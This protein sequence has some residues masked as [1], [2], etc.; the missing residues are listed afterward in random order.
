MHTTTPV[1]SR[2]S[3]RHE[4]FLWRDSEQFRSEL[5][6]FIEE[7]LATGEAVM[8][9]LITEHA[10]WL[11]AGLGADAAA[12]VHFVDM[13][14]LGANPARVI[15]A[16]QQFLDNHAGY[17]QPAR[18][19]GEPIWAG[20]R[21]EEVQE[22][23]LH[24]ALLNVAID[25]ELPFWLICPYNST[26]L[27]PAVIS[28]AHRSHPAVFGPDFYQ[29]SP[30][31]AGRSH[32]DS[33]FTAD[34]QPL[35]GQPAELAFTRQNVDEVYGFVT[36]SAYAADLGADEA[37][38]LGAAARCLAAASM[39]RGAKDGVI[40]VWSQPDAVICEIRDDAPVDDP[41]IGRRAST[42]DA[43]WTANQDCDLVQVRATG[44][45]TTVR[46]HAWR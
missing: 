13:A 5:V 24:E 40:R 16:W 45:H 11:R 34:L 2:Q 20:R 17:A 39:E 9:A 46:L 10:D 4:A 15:P 8:V 3:Y 36:S 31:Y 12:Q 33:L 41:L 30:I 32:V 6:P 14:K 18:G 43:V 7:G 28:E 29:G 42:A 19:I 27:P 22:C 37:V 38:R 35:P 21:A 1:R 23:Q 44:S 25:P 26:E